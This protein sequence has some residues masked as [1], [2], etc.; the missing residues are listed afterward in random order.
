MNFQNLNLNLNH[1]TDDEH[2]F[3]VSTLSPRRTGL[4]RSRAQ[5]RTEGEGWCWEAAHRWTR[6]GAAAVVDGGVGKAP[7]S[8]LDEKGCI[9]DEPQHKKKDGTRPVQ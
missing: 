4:A 7:D 8:V 5:T 2:K 6:A 1:R 9:K 3:T